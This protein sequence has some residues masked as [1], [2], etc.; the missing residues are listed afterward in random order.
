MIITLKKSIDNR[1]WYHHLRG[2]VVEGMMTE[3]GFVADA[4]Y[5]INPHGLKTTD[6]LIISTGDINY[7]ISNKF[8]KL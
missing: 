6:S 7:S 1:R 3:S 4:K 5:S 2:Q 8:E